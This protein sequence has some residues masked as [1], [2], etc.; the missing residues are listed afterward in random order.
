VLFYDPNKR[1]SLNYCVAQKLIQRCPDLE[2]VF[3]EYMPEAYLSGQR[4]FIPKSD[5]PSTKVGDIISAEVLSGKLDELH[6][7]ALTR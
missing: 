3:I 2:G 6:K 7:L 4:S 1:G 5:T